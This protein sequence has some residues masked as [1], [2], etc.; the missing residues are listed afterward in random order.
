VLSRSA[1]SKTVQFAL[2]RQRKNRAAN[3]QQLVWLKQAAVCRRLASYR[4]AQKDVAYTTKVVLL[5]AGFPV[6]LGLGGAEPPY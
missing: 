3:K 6:L 4:R 5:A 1:E 2:T